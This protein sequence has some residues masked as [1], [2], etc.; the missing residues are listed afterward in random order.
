AVLGPIESALPRIA[1]YYRWQIMLKSSKLEPLHRLIQWLLS[2]QGS[3]F[4]NRQV[5]V[6]VDVDPIFMM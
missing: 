5:K 3:L 4:N 2:N 1:T 6:A